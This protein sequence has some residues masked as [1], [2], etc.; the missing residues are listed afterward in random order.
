MRALN[1][2]NQLLK[3][4]IH[5]NNQWFVTFMASLIY[6]GIEGGQLLSW[7]V[8]ACTSLSVCALAY[9]VAVFGGGY[10]HGVHGWR[11][12]LIGCFCHL[13]CVCVC[14]CM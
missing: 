12:R 2:H 10:S 11:E 6:T 7:C 1:S 8:C 9:P 13:L 4:Q 5:S 14:V 3:K